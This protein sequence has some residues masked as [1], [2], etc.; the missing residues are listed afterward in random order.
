MGSARSAFQ[1]GMLW[2]F[3]GGVF[4]QIC[5]FISSIFVIRKLEKIDYGYYVDA[6]NIYSYLV[7]FIGMGFISAILQYCSENRE[8]SEKNCIY[9]YSRRKGTAF[10]LLLSV[11][12][13]GISV[14]RLLQGDKMPGIYIGMMSLLPFVVYFNNYNQIILRVKRK[15][16]EYGI[17]HIA[18]SVSIVIGNI[19]I[20]KLW[21]VA[22]LIIST[23]LSNI[24]AALIGRL[25]LKKLSFYTDIASNIKEIGKDV[26]K[27]LNKYA[28]LC[29]VTNFSS[30]V[31]VLLDITV[32]NAVLGNAEVLADY[33]VGSVV[34]TACM[35]IPSS[36]ITFFYPEIVAKIE[37][38]RKEFIPYFTKLTVTFL[39]IN[40][41]VG[42]VLFFGSGIII[43]TIY[44]ERYLSAVG[45]MQLLSVNFIVTASFHRLFGNVIAALKK[46]HINLILSIVSGVVNIGLDILLV[47][48]RGSQGAAIATLIVSCLTTV[49]EVLFIIHYIKKD[50]LGNN[51]QEIKA[52]GDDAVL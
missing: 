11:V 46:V 47:I 37:R 42:A 51:L 38:G 31:L 25:Y 36:L 10:N 30:S 14:V 33:R 49:L 3:G 5:S 28:L 52:E 9:K 20:T 35:F 18:Y 13:I 21:G 45:I 12:I 27:E 40:G 15:N 29:A 8:S 39:I 24:V 17:V 50:M 23:Y 4:S 7:A 43:K 44:G 2:I 6:S 41:I 22:G 1:N 34:P 26:K 16:K 48:N 19:L 32:L